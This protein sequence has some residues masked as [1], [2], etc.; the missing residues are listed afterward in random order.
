[1]IL[2]KTDI[3]IM[4]V[5]NVLGY[6]STDL[7]TLCSCDKINMW[8]KYKPVRNNFTTNRPS[9]W[10]RAQTG[11]CGI[12][13]P[14]A[15]SNF[16]NIINLK[17]EYEQPR[18]GSSEPYRLGD[19]AGYDS[20]A[21]AQY[22]VEFPELIYNNQKNYIRVRETG[23]SDTALLMSDIMGYQPDEMYLIAC[24]KC[25]S[26]NSKSTVYATTPD[27]F[28]SSGLGNQTITLNFDETCLNW[29]LNGTTEI[30]V[31]MCNF[32][33]NGVT[34]QIPTTP[35]PLYYPLPF[36]DISEIRRTIS[37][38]GASS[39]LSY[40]VILES[41]SIT[42]ISYSQIQGTF[43]VINKNEDQLDRPFNTQDASYSLYIT[44]EVGRDQWVND[45]F[46]ELTPSG[47]YLLAYNETKTFT[48]RVLTD[49]VY[50][51]PYTYELRIEQEYDGA[52]RQL[53]HTTGE[54]NI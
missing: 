12:K 40:G 24:I 16:D 15:T 53:G 52:I 50:P 45:P 37:N 32:K 19:F 30:T 36:S 23:V 21:K 18:G 22:T 3:S 51:T 4:D 31:G 42:N 13:V 41:I 47:S 5:R 26:T 17:Y 25:N 27:P 54:Y 7:G 28:T 34:A 38:T 10:W 44:T 20:N 6:P 49:Y 43:T 39:A 8:A 29:F 33:L 1:M 14:S 48:F 9:D 35:A 2:P 11:N 46:Y